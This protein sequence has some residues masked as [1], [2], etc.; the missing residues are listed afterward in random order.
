MRISQMTND[1]VTDLL[2]RVTTPISNIMD[3]EE[4]Q[5]LIENVAKSREMPP[6]QIVAKLLP[7]FV[8]FA[9]RKHKA[10]L[11]E[12]VGAFAMKSTRDVG[13]MNILETM[14]LLKDSIDNDF[15]DF[16]TSSSGQE[17]KQG[18]G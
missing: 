6:V 7:M 4:A 18:E 11:Y 2:I 10:D 9:I 8:N 17:R 15:I 13:K 3:D 14:N 12:I 1:Q 16:F 5:P